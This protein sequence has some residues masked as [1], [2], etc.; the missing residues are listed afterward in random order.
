MGTGSKAF[1][2]KKVDSAERK[3]NKSNLYPGGDLFCP[4]GSRVIRPFSLVTA[5]APFCTTPTPE[6]LL[7]LFCPISIDAAV[8]RPKGLSVAMHFGFGVF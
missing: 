6:P 7:F 3:A 1:S 4:A 2:R 8:A 5:L